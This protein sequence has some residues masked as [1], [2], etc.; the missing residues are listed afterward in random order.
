MNYLE[1]M[2]NTQPMTRSNFILKHEVNPRISGLVFEIKPSDHSMD[3]GKHRD[4]IKDKNFISITDIAKRYG[5]FIDK[6]APWRFVA[7][8]NSTPMRNRMREDYGYN[9][10]SE[11]F[12]D[13]YYKAYLYDMEIIKTYIT[14]F[15]NSFA[16]SNPVTNI[17]IPNVD[18]NS[19]RKIITR[20]T[21]GTFMMTD[22]QM[23]ALYYFIRAKESSKIWTQQN[24]DFEVDYAW[25]I[26]KANGV[27]DALKYINFKTSISMAN[28]G[29][30]SNRYR[31]QIKDR[32]IDN[33]N[34]SKS[35]RTFK[36]N[37]L[38]Y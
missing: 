37:I 33:P 7:D 1:F 28:G 8:I 22:K 19:T 21:I 35:P 5:F 23:L 15:Y 10:I 24:F 34:S 17:I 31:I 11:M 30:P 9:T 13:I 26:F 20:N 14:S 2:L 3:F 4:F 27:F 36:F 38:R 25:G 6:N 12:D 29:N 16:A 32:I 18:R